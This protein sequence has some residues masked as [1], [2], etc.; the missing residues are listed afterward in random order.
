MIDPVSQSQKIPLGAAAASDRIVPV[1]A[2]RPA[3]FTISAQFLDT[4]NLA[5]LSQLAVQILADPLA[6][7]QLSDRVIELLHQDLSLQQE[8]SR[9]YGR[10]G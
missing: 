5:E 7:Q 6:V 9:G 2:V 8:R 10:R 1:V 4:T 3:G